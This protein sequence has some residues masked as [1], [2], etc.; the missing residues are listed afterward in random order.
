MRRS[1]KP[2]ILLLSTYLTGVLLLVPT[3][4]HA[5]ALNLSAEQQQIMGLKTAT[6]QQVTAY[7]SASYSA[8]AMIPLNKR[9]QVSATVSGKVVALHH[10]HGEINQGELIAEIASPEF[11]QMQQQLIMAV[12]DLEVAKQDLK[13]A[14][15]LSKSGVSSVK[16][17]N[18]IRADVTK[19]QAEKQQAV[20]Q[21]QMTGLTQKALN[22]LIKTQEIQVQNLNVVSNVDGQ[23]YDLEVKLNQYIDKGQTLV[24]IGETN[25]MIFEAFVSQRF[26]MQL[27]EGQRVRLP[28]LDKE[29][30]IG[31][32]HS[33]VDEMTQTV[34]VHIKVDNSDKQIFKGQFSQV[35]FLFEQPAYQIS[36]AAISQ[37]GTD[38]VVFVETAEGIESRLI[39]VLSIT[40]DQLFFTF[41]EASGSKVKSIYVQGSTAIKSAFAATE[42]EE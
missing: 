7:P 36:V 8:R 23:V 4:S 12:A 38:K 27:Q 16:N 35:Q 42:S 40:N 41:K 6:L 21:L 15:A 30:V 33:E 31:H 39:E 9:H 19:L 5:Q 32:V 17:L 37:I 20:S 1:I 11:I 26:A 18:A 2:T 25:P 3:V 22:T 34:D 14:Q 28:A 29:G 10:S 24:T 13:R